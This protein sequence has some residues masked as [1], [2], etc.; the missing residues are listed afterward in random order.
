MTW[1][2][3]WHWMHNSNL[4]M[5][6]CPNIPRRID[7]S[8]IIQ[9][10]IFKN[11]PNVQYQTGKI[12]NL[13]PHSVC[14]WWWLL[15]LSIYQTYLS[16]L[17]PPNCLFH[18]MSTKLRLSLNVSLIDCR[19]E[20]LSTESSSLWRMWKS[21][22]GIMWMEKRKIMF[23]PSPSM[24]RQDMESRWALSGVDSEII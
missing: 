16:S 11:S 24:D 21:R 1:R 9:C 13:D 14:I 22:H 8:S 18:T 12:S 3:F 10:Q 23:C 19:V 4:R 6:L 7:S 5:I 17:M 20:T 2:H 15:I